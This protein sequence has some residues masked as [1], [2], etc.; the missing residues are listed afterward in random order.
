MKVITLSREYCAGGHSIARA[1][2][3]K[4]GIE[5][6]DK[7]IIRAMAAESSVDA[8]KLEKSGEELTGMDS[9]IRSITPISYDQ[10]EYLFELQKKVVLELAS[11]GPC[12]ILGR[13]ADVFLPEAGIDCLNVFVY[14]DPIHKA[15]RCGE[16][17]GSKDTAVIAKELKK[18]ERA[19][20]QYYEHFTG[21]TFGD[22]HN[23]DLALNSGALGY[24]RCVEIICDAARDCS[25]R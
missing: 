24:D 18:T 14:S 4:L 17:I 6:Y 2:A 16:L 9:F 13:C 5:I 25:G 1:A 21:Q 12:I 20:R 7:D 10:K 3:A 8:D 11:K 19:R 15:V 22:V 23:Y